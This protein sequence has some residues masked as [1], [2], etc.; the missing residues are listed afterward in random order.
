ML[1]I[2]TRRSNW[3]HLTFARSFARTFGLPV[4]L[5]V[6]LL[7]AATMLLPACGDDDDDPTPPGCTDDFCA[8]FYQ[9]TTP[10]NVLRNLKLAYE[11]RDIEMYTLCFAPDSPSR[12]RMSRRATRLPSGRSPMSSNRPQT[13]SRTSP[14]TES[15]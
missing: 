2:A 6:A 5:P 13:C 10:E 4:A 1:T 8:P 3:T 12:R 7:A 11:S 9:P 15:R 14:S